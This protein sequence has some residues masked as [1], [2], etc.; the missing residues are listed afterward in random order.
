VFTFEE[1]APAHRDSSA[2]STSLMRNVLCTL[3]FWLI[4]NGRKLFS[5]HCA[6]KHAR[7]AIF[8]VAYRPWQNIVCLS[9]PMSQRKHRAVCCLMIGLGGLKRSSQ[10]WW[11]QPNFEM[12][13]WKS[14]LNGSALCGERRR[15][16]YSPLSCSYT[17]LTFSGALTSVLPSDNTSKIRE[18]SERKRRPLGVL[19]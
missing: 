18:S 7:P 17:R 8:D 19:T 11:P 6:Y 14:C 16:I 1:A 13:P 12:P 5:P 15:Q 9:I 2:P 3:S 4:E 10:L